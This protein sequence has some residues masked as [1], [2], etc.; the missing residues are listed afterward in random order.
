MERFTTQ[1]FNITKGLNNMTEKSIH[2]MSMEEKFKEL[3]VLRSHKHLKLFFTLTYL[4]RAQTWSFYFNQYK[5][6]I[7]SKDVEICLDWAV[8]FSRAIELQQPLNYT[9]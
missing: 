7:K 4:E 3:E 1:I 8:I 9:I 2:N 5:V 6:G